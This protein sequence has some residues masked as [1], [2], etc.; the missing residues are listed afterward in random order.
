MTTNLAGAEAGTLTWGTRADL[1]A[2]VLD[3]S[4]ATGLL[5]GTPTADIAVPLG[6]VA[7]KHAHQLTKATLADA[8]LG[9][10]DRVVV[11]LN[12]DGDLAGARVAE[13]AADI[14]ESA[15]SVG[16][17]GRMRLLETL[18]RTRSDVLVATPT[19]VADLL[20]RLHLEFLVDP[21]DLELRL[22]LLTGEITD[23]K[24]RRHLAREFGATV[25]ELY[26][27]PVTGIPVAHRDDAGRLVPA[28]PG[29]L[30]L[31]ALDDN[32]LIDPPV[33]GTRAEIVVRHT[34][35]PELSTVAI[36]TG[37]VTIAGEAGVVPAPL[38]TVGESV[39]VRG[40]W[41][42]LTAVRKALAK[43]DGISRWRFEISR[44][45]TL[46]AALLTVSFNRDSLIRN[47]MWK[48]R[49]EQALTAL[50]PVKIEVAVDE[51]VQEEPLPPEVVDHRGHHLG[52]DRS[53][54]A[55]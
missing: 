15:I 48:S 4:K 49:I 16:P 20:A 55:R 31:A 51:Q 41:L 24:T 53:A 19:G 52:T 7:R 22:I 36:R 13:A 12:S 14:A 1:A 42:S 43:I 38:H 28:E 39:L 46:D 25:V 50:T 2:T 44:D 30:A 23:D 27:D 40:R 47:G 26:T 10:G 5:A 32:T 11:A 54:L 21:L 9:A 45:G 3:P 37:H 34:W 8:G 29:L 33:P 18:Q 17:R 6:P 35:H